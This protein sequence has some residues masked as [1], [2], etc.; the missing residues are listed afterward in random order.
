MVKLLM[1]RQWKIG[2]T[3][4]F[5]HSKGFVFIVSTVITGRYIYTSGGVKAFYNISVRNEIVQ[6]KKKK[7]SSSFSNSVLLEHDLFSKLS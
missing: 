5:T 3:L 7:H 1:Y 4:V 2:P 6:I